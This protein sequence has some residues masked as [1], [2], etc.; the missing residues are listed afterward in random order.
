MQ[1]NLLTRL[2]ALVLLAPINLLLA[3]GLAVEAASDGTGIFR[4]MGAWLPLWAWSALWLVA[5]A[6]QLFAALNGRVSFYR[7]GIIAGF[8]LYSAAFLATI[9]SRFVEGADLTLFAVGILLFPPLVHLLIIVALSVPMGTTYWS[10]QG[11][12]DARSV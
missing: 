2:W 4:I 3:L 8:G 7:V 12:R 11:R 10:D 1:L 6:I 5:G 9:W